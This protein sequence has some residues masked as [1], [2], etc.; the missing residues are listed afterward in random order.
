MLKPKSEAWVGGATQAL[1]AVDSWTGRIHVHKLL[2]AMKVFQ[3][4]FN[5]SGIL[6][7]SIAIGLSETTTYV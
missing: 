5:A 3:P 4:F 1:R 2:F 6:N 7:S